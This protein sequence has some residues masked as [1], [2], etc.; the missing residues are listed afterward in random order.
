[1]AALLEA[2]ATKKG[3]VE[4][5]ASEHGLSEEPLLE[6]VNRAIAPASP[7]SVRS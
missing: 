6:W 3:R 4:L 7:F 2:G 5:A 1:V